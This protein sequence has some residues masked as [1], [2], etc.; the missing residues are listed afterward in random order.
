MNKTTCH[1]STKTKINGFEFNQTTAKKFNI[2][3]TKSMFLETDETPCFIG[4]RHVRPPKIE[5][6][7]EKSL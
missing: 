4:K 7:R 2:K 3:D 6:E 1:I 5:I